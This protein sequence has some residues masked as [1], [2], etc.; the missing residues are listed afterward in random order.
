MVPSGSAVF[1][2][3]RGVHPA[4]MAN[5]HSLKFSVAIRLHGAIEYAAA[6][7]SV[8]QRLTNVSYMDTKAAPTPP[9]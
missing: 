6:P 2:Q 5:L 1:L 7:H 9:F 8:V 4:R 3:S